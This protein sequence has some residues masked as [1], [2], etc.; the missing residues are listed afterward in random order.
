MGGVDKADMMRTLYGYKRKSVKWWHRLFWGMIDMTV[1]NA[2][3][4]IQE[5]KTKSPLLDF[6]RSV[7]TTLLAYGKAKRLMPPVSRAIPAT[8]VVGRGIHWP[9]FT[10][11][12]G[13]FFSCTHLCIIS[14]M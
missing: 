14:C 6:V 8:A 9:K 11:Q 2:H 5:V 1:V 7:A 12:R 3:V 4:I 10:E 13:L